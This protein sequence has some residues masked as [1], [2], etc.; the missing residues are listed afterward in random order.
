[1]ILIKFFSFLLFMNLNNSFKFINHKSNNRIYMGCDY[2]IEDNL[3]IYYNDNTND[4]IQLN[5]RK[6]YYTD[7]DIYNNFITDIEIENSIFAEWDKIKQYHLKPKK[8]SIL[9]YSNNTFNNTYLSNKYEEMI[10]YKIINNKY[11][12]W[13]DIKEIIISEDRYK[14][15]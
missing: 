11:K 3:W 12:T 9:I 1:M 5:R 7:T 15:D 6:G 2:Y 14:R 8:K 4:Y 13:N 10:D